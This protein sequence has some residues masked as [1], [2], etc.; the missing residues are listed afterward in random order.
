[1][2]KHTSIKVVLA[3]VAHYDLAFEQ[4]DVK[5]TFL[6]GDLEEQIY[7]KQPEGFSQPGQ[8]HLVCKLKKSFYGPK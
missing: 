1:V 6:H 3:L 8:E 7:M 4:M 2:V 5:T